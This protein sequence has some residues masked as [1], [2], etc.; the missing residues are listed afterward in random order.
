MLESG[1]I[2][3]TRSNIDAAYVGKAAQRVGCGDRRDLV[4]DDVRGWAYGRAVAKGGHQRES[5]I[6]DAGG[7]ERPGLPPEATIYTCCGSLQVLA[8]EIVKVPSAAVV[9][10]LA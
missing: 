2:G 4:D 10:G 8:P 6:V 1:R 9:V 7:V 3:C 5:G